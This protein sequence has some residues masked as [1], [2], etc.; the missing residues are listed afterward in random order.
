MKKIFFG[1]IIFIFYSLCACSDFLELY[2]VTSLN[3]G[4]FFRTENELI[5]L[6]NGCYVPMRNNTKVTKWI[7]AEMRSDNSSYQKPSDGGN[8]ARVACDEFQYESNN[9][10]FTDLWNTTYQ[11]IYRCNQLLGNVDRTEISWTKESY[12]ERSKG[13]AYFL[14]AL[15]YFD[16]VRQFGGVPVVKTAVSAQDAINIKRS[17]VEQVYELIISDLNEAI[18]HF[19][20]ATDVQENG[21]AN[22]QA[23]ISLLGSV[24]L[25]RH[26]YPE[27][28]SAFNTVISS[29]KYVLR[30]NYSDLFNPSIKDYLET[31]FAIQYSEANADL[32]NNFVFNF[33]PWRSGGEITNRPNVNLGNNAGFN[34]PTEDLINIFEPDD[35]RKEVAI[36]FWTGADWDLQIRTIPY[37]AKYKPP[38]SAPDNRCG[39]NFPVIRY[40][41]VLLMYAEALNM[42]GKTSQAIPYVEQVRTRAGLTN[43]LSGYDKIALEKMIADERQRELCFENHRWYDLL[44]TGKAIE[45][46]TAHG[47]REIALKSYL[48]LNSYDLKEY[49]LLAPIPVEEILRNKI[50]QNPGY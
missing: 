39:D 13:E 41:D 42:Q 49:K 2:P 16:L 48:S 24:F 10:H 11:G 20:Q 43:P 17:S 38:L 35:L 32:A 6:A 47:Q 46:M 12:K 45:V 34:Q 25:T 7:V 1:S 5:L 3:E 36:Q 21:R 9:T 33:I 44:R 23:A 8:W 19:R 37:C 31:I 30:E 27:A 18:N 22:E 14:R 40:A 26:A 50:E 15:Y 4:N 28:E 29:R